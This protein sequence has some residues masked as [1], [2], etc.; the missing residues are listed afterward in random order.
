MTEKPGQSRVRLVVELIVIA[1]V[2]TGSKALYDQVDWRFAGPV[3]MACTIAT[4]AV[5]FQLRRESWSHLGFARL[6]RWWSWPLVLPQGLLGAVAILAVG[7]GTAYGGD[8]LGFWSVDGPQEGVEARW[9]DIEGNLQVYLLWLAI[10][11]TSAAF[12]EEIFFRAYLIDRVGR[13]LP[14]TRW[15]TFIAILI[16]AIIFGAVHAYYQGL[17]GFVVTGLIGLALGGLYLLNKRNL[18]PNILAH[19]LVDTLAFTAMYL[20]LDI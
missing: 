2:L 13:L 4:I 18:W 19:G 11:W 9:G 7:A 17:R 8:A 12:G 3:S 16:P 6:R 15:A 20:D 14:D 5:I 1:I 10:V